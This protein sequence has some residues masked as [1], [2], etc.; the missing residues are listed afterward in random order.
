MSDVN[1]IVFGMSFVGYCQEILV[2][3]S[4]TVCH[5]IYYSASTAW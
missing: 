3:I 4:T 1:W 5:R 2:S